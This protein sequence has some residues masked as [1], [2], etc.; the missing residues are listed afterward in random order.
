LSASAPTAPPVEH[1]EGTVPLPQPLKRK[2]KDG[3]VAVSLANWCFVSVW[4][5]LFNNIDFGFFNIIPLNRPTLLAL[6]ANIF[7]LA[8]VFWLVLRA[9]R[10]WQN[11]WFHLIVHL[12]F[13]VLMVAPV[14]FH[15]QTHAQHALAFLLHQPAGLFIT[16][17][18]GALIL[19]KHRLVARVATIVVAILSPLAVYTLGKLVLLSLGIFIHL[20]VQPDR[21][22]PVPPGPVHQGRPRVVWII[23]DEA[24]Y[25][26]IFDQRP[27][28][29]ELPEFDRLRGESLSANNANSPTESTITSM[30]SLILGYR[31]SKAMLT[32]SYDLAVQFV[33]TNGTYWCSQRP[34]VFSSARAMGVN[35]AVVGWYLPYGKLFGR[36][37]N[38]CFWRPFPVYNPSRASTFGD[39]M[40]RQI[41]CLSGPLHARQDTVA[42]YQ[43]CL[44]ESTALVT[45]TAYGLMLFHM[46]PPHYP[47]IYLRDKNQFTARKMDTAAGYFNNLALADR[48]LGKLRHALE[49]SGEWETTWTIVSADHSWRF[50]REYDGQHD[51]RVPFLVNPPGANRPVVYSQS[52]NTVATRSLIEAILRGEITNRTQAVADW[53]KVN[54]PEKVT[55]PGTLIGP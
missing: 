40:W 12:L 20:P 36:D 43:Q 4:Y 50:S 47:G 46:F 15:A 6:L 3:I 16:I 41:Q 11:R 17:V 14:F 22:S 37:L 18:I 7:L 35:T 19:W 9:W 10:R 53:L 28:G 21:F 51:Y 23:F 49:M 8:A 27:A 54:A 1:Y 5:R 13:I 48:T 38:Y 34:S 52:F 2:I 32:N 31:I 24:D 44:A 30:P 33:I 25:R 26:M 29:L 42:M 45:N 55:V 39:A